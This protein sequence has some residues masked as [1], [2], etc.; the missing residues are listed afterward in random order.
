MVFYRLSVHLPS[1][2][3]FIVLFQGQGAGQRQRTE[4]YQ[5]PPPNAPGYNVY[6]PLD[7]SLDFFSDGDDGG[8]D[9]GQNQGIK[10]ASAVIPD[11]GAAA[12]PARP[13]AALPAA[14]G[15]FLF[16]PNL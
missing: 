14:A 10:A 13:A 16:S 9:D 15:I 1:F 6:P 5:P 2:Q 7:V 12:L 11:P 4:V 8:Q 3:W